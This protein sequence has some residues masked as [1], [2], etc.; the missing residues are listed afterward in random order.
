LRAAASEGKIVSRTPGLIWVR[1]LV[2]GDVMVDGSI[3]EERL[4][5]LGL[6]WATARGREPC[7]VREPAGSVETIEDQVGC[8]ETITLVASL[9]R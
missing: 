9:S 7:A 4:R 6:S 3:R 2:V 1:D 8:V 5:P